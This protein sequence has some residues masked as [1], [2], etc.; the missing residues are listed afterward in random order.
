MT[1]RSFTSSLSATALASVVLPAAR[2]P[3]MPIHGGCGASRASIISAI[4]AVLIA[5]HAIACLGCC[6]TGLPLEVFADCSINLHQLHGGSLDL[7]H[8]NEHAR[9]WAIGRNQDL[10]TLQ[11]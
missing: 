3:S 8:G 4:S 10:V 7:N 6:H 1:L 11:G 2:K 5:F 9:A